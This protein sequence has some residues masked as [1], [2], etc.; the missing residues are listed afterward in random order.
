MAHRKVKEEEEAEINLIDNLKNRL[1][2]N[3]S[4]KSTPLDQSGT[5]KVSSNNPIDVIMIGK[6]S[7]GTDWTTDNRSFN[8]TSVFIQ[9]LKNANV[10]RKSSKENVGLEGKKSQKTDVHGM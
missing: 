2:Q 10:N 3:S 4:L 7:S 5:P 8:L 9:V 6:A 1:K